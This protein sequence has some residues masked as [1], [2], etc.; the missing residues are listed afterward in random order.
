MRLRLASL[1][2][3]LPLLLLATHTAH[4]G[5]NEPAYGLLVEGTALVPRGDVARSVGGGLEAA[6]MPLTTRRVDDCPAGC[7]VTN[8]TNPLWLGVGAFATFGED[9]PGQARRNV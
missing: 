8:H 3:A 2:L 4:A 5:D 9:T 6:M 7:I 1:A